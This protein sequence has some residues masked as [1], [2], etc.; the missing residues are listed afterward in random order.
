MNLHLPTVKPSHNKLTRTTHTLF[1]I[2]VIFITTS[3][4]KPVLQNHFFVKESKTIFRSD[5]SLETIVAV[6]EELKGVIDES[7]KNFAFRINNNSFKGFNSALQ[8]EHFNENYL[9]SERNPISTFTGKIIDEIDFSKP[10]IYIVRAKGML[11]LRGIQRE[12]IIRGTLE[13]KPGF[14]ELKTTF[15]VMLDDYDIRIP[16]IVYQKIA[17]DIHVSI[18]AKLFKSN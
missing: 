3:F 1:C 11:Q 17:P 14:I 4:I 9:E 5:A 16:R 13:V 18:A 6:S 7:N 8:K 12:R 2:V 15:V 10:G